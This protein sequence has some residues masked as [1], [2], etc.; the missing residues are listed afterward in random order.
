MTCAGSD[1]VQ[2][3]IGHPLTD[4]MVHAR[5]IGASIVI[6]EISF[7]KPGSRVRQ[8][9][10]DKRLNAI[11]RMLRSILD[12]CDA[13][14]GDLSLDYSWCTP[15]QKKVIA[16]ARKIPRGTTV[17]YAELADMAGYPRALRAAAS[18]MRYNR[19]P[20]IIPCH[21]VIRSDGTIGG[22][23]GREHGWTVNLKR[24]LLA[25]ERRTTRRQDVAG[26]RP[27]GPAHSTANVRTFPC[28]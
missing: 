23:M 3:L 20:L 22:F 16:S 5:T 6:T 7:R 1:Q 13:D 11:V 24:K 14:T 2:A 19:F 12:G 10:Q 26:K 27:A 21:R 4:L 15:F 25:N 9:G 17:S 28:R 18:V 8:S